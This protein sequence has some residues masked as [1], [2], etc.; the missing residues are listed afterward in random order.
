MEVEIIFQEHFTILQL[1]QNLEEVKRKQNK[2]FHLLS[3]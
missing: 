2:N 1:Q 3:R